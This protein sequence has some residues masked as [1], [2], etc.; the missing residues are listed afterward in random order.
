MPKFT[1]DHPS[2]LPAN[3]ALAKIK[4]FFEN[5]QDIRRIDPKIQCRFNESELKGDVTGSQFKAQVKVNPDGAGSKISVT[6][7]L[8]LLLT[9]FKGKVEEMIK[10]KLGKNL[11]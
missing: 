10:K 3:D 8:P 4:T 2:T 11:A 5:D 6:I 9:P 1:V 7:D